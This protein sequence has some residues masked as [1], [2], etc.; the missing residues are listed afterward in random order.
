MLLGALAAGWDGALVLGRNE[1]TC[2]LDGAEAHARETVDRT[3]RL[4][5]LLGL[6]RGR[7]RFVDPEPGSEGPT[8][9]MERML[10]DLSASPL[11]RRLPFDDPDDTADGALAVA[12]WLSGREELEI[13]GAAWLEENDLPAARP[14]APAL[15]A[16]AA[17]YLDLLAGGWLRPLKLADQLRHGLRVLRELGFEAGVAVNGLGAGWPG[18][19]RRYPGSRL[20]GLCSGCAAEANEAGLEVSSLN[21]LLADEG[22]RLAEGRSFPLLALGGDPLLERLAAALGAPSVEVGPAPPLGLKLG[23]RPA[24]RERLE[25]RLIRSAGE[26]AGALLVNGPAELVQCAL[27]LREGAWRRTAVRAVLACEVVAGAVD[28]DG[29]SGAGR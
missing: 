3:E 16:N 17:P 21:D 25:A 22:A 11:L 1:A 9:A 6:G 27:V 24:D 13:D 7:A 19:A 4:A 10:G 12:S 5:R 20:F 15:L 8:S 23:V 2:R 29:E 18:V 26:G 14:G 28:S